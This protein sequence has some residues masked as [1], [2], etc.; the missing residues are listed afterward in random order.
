MTA[1]EAISGWGSGSGS[2]LR[3]SAGRG[4]PLFR[5]LV[6]SDPDGG[7]WGAACGDQAS[8]T[9]AAAETAVIMGGLSR[10]SP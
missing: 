7:V 9:A 4:G 6:M 10:L 8:S 2:G 1:A 5:L 3:Y